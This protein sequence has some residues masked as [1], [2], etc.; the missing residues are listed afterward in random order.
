MAERPTLADVLLG[1][2]LLSR[3]LP[4]SELSYDERRELDDQLSGRTNA[5]TERQPPFDWR[6][7]LPGFQGGHDLARGIGEG[8]PGLAAWGAAQVGLSLL[9]L[10]FRAPTPRAPTPQGPWVPPTGRVTTDALE[11]V[12][13]Q[14]GVTDIRRQTAATG[15]EYLHFANPL[16]SGA[17]RWRNITVRIPADAHAAQRRWQPG[18]IFDLAS[19]RARGRVHGR[20]TAFNPTLNVG[21][22]RFNEWENLLP[23][24]QWRLSRAPNGGSWL[25]REDQVP[26]GLTGGAMVDPRIFPREAPLA[27][28]AGLDP[29]QLRLLGTAGAGAMTAPWLLPQSAPQN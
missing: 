1:R 27:A 26:R 7:L 18:N 22:G 16:D 28:P 23:A 19:S 29:R 11:D 12:L 14:I 24:L 17:R 13:G 10:G 25:V 20:H 8:S 5:L 4:S 15:T 2:P 9:P 21:G 3:G 6:T